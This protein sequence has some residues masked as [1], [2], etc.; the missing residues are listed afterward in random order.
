MVNFCEAGSSGRESRSLGQQKTPDF[1]LL[2]VT[3][4]L[5]TPFYASP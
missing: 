3:P 2:T 4:S 1:E 5:Y